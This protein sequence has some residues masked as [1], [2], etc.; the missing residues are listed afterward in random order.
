ML[1]IATESTD[2]EACRWCIQAS[3]RVQAKDNH[4]ANKLK[5]LAPTLGMG[6][7]MVR[8]RRVSAAV[9]C[10]TGGCLLRVF[11]ILRATAADDVLREDC[12]CHRT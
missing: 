3:D 4:S 12:R 10:E 1:H 9:R 6:C 11:L 5:T 7:M 8:V 2:T